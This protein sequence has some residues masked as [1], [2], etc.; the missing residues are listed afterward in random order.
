[1][2]WSMLGFLAAS[3]IMTTMLSQL[4][5]DDRFSLTT[6]L[7]VMLA[8]T[9]GAWAGNVYLR[10]SAIFTGALV[11]ATLVSGGLLLLLHRTGLLVQ[12]A[13]LS[14][15]PDTTKDKHEIL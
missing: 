8:G 4:F 10:D 2:L 12:E 3:F 14:N 11:G 13:E 1:M 15:L 6:I 9:A 5:P 7:L